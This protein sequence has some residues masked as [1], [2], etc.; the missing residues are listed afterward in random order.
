LFLDVPG[1]ELGIGVLPVT[2]G[3]AGGHA[4]ER[5]AGFHDLTEV[6]GRDGTNPGAAGLFESDQAFPLQ[7]DQGFADGSAA[8]LEMLG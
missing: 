3:E 4:F 2:V 1:H 8:R 7:S 6:L 5:G